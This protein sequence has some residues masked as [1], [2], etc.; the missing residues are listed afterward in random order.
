M[1][2]HLH[3]A[4]REVIGQKESKSLR[5]ASMEQQRHFGFVI[6]RR[7]IRNRVPHALR[8]TDFLEVENVRQTHFFLM[9]A[10]RQPIRPGRAFQF[11]ER[12]QQFFPP[13]PQRII[14]AARPGSVCA[15]Q[16]RFVK[17]FR[18]MVHVDPRRIMAKYTPPFVGAG[19]AKRI[20]RLLGHQEGSQRP[21]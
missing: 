13:Q 2:A 14:R 7:P 10:I 21:G 19:P 15:S 6:Q 9:D 3:G 8:R 20:R 17:R 16:P 5:L 18:L 12:H 4:V 11:R 1:R